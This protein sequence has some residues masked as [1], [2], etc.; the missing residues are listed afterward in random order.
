MTASLLHGKDL[1]GMAVVDI[2]TGDDL[3]DVRDVVFHPER[4]LLAGLILMKRNFWHGRMREVLPIDGIASIGTHAV[5]VS[6]P[7]ALADR[8]DAPSEMTRPDRHRDVLDNMVVT[9]SGRQLGRIVDVIIVGG[10][11]PRVV[12]FQVSG[13]AVG[14]GL[15]PIGAKS[16]LSGTTLVVPDDYETRIRTDL[17][18]LAAELV[19][20]ERARS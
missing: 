2:S 9:E 1:A 20:I 17:T 5:M 16:G 19:E 8:S 6:D 18:G 15:V 3:A 7:G 13:G 12:G 10:D 14:D 4:G 11:A